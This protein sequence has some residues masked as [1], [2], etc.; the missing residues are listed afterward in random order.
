[1]LKLSVLISGYFFKTGI[2][3][4][5]LFSGDTLFFQNVGR[6]DLPTGDEQTLPVSIKEK[7]YSLPDETVVYPGHGRKTDVG[8]EK[9]YETIKNETLL[10]IT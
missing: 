9:K 2:V 3:N 1:M 7:I 4:D 6:W 5:V 8:Y 10:F